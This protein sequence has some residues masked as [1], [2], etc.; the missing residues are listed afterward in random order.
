VILRKDE[1]QKFQKDHES[2]LKKQMNKYIQTTKQEREIEKLERKEVQEFLELKDVA[3]VF[4]TYQR[5]LFHMFKFY[6]AQ[7]SHKDK[8]AYDSEWL[9]STLSY[10]E[11]VRW[12]YQQDITPNLVTPEDMV[13]IYKTLVREQEDI[14][15]ESAE[16]E[17][18]VKSGM[19][20]YTMFKKAM[21]RI[22]IRSQEK[23]GGGNQDLLE[24]KLNEET[25]VRE[26]KMRQRDR[27]MTLKSKKEALE[28]EKMDQLRQQ[29]QQEQ[30]YKES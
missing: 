25:R 1:Q 15:Q 3:A 26:G 23:L 19:I 28:K 4:D 18:R 20:D 2:K 17:N 22:S 30:E 9:V 12:S 29:F 13:Y 7:D 14:L 11:L 24:A 16:A 27:V 6:A 5:Q 10:K 8:L 21:C